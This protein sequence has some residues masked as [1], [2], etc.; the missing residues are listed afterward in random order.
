LIKILKKTFS[1]NKR[2]WHRNITNGFQE[3]RITP[4]SSTKHSLFSLVYGKDDILLIHL[5]L[6]ALS[7]TI[8][9]EYEEGTTP[10]Q[11][12]FYQLIQLDEKI[13]HTMSNTQRKKE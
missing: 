6:H 12:H 9:I 3:S 8:G 13:S 2:Y 4:K 11:N 5:E 1:T 7:I 10:L